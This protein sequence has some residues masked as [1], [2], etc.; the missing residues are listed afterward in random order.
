M[1][2]HSTAEAD[3]TT[4]VPPD[5]AL[6]YHH[7]ENLDQ[8]HE[9]SML[10]MW[11]FLATE[12]LFFGGLIMAYVVYRTIYHESF[13]AA[14]RR[15]DVVLGG[16]NTVVLLTSSLTMAL[17]VRSAQLRRRAMTVYMLIA[18]MIFG[19]GFLVI[20]GFEYYAEYQEDL[21][22]F[23]N[24]H[25]EPEEGE[26]G[27][28]ESGGETLTA[29]E[30]GEIEAD[31]GKAVRP[32]VRRPDWFN[33]EMAEPPGVVDPVLDRYTGAEPRS[34][35]ESRARL[36][37]VLYF[38][39]T[40]LHAIHLI[41]GIILVGVIAALVGTS[42]FSGFGETQVEVTGLYWHFIDIVWVFLYPLLYLIDIHQ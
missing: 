27:A 25:W 3:P 15:L 41:I 37:F 38:F 12:V 21:I 9:A 19:A 29:T 5:P 42:W 20:K 30:A 22:P 6:L 11:V 23:I 13:V 36:F 24:F 8:Q 31:T 18:T 32:G 35:T 7:F 1:T 4:D 16:I 33:P 10:G 26:H 39:M 2:A 14:G 40:G 34:L 28:A 17:A